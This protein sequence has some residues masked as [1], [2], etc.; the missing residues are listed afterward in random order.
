MPLTRARKALS[1]RKSQS[2]ME[3]LMTYGWAILIIAV[4]LGVLFQLGIFSGSSLTP[5]AQPGSCEVIRTAAATSLE[6]LC[7]GQLP[8][9]VASFNG[10]AAGFRGP[11][12]TLDTITS[13]YTMCAWT[14]ISSYI[15]SSYYPIL[16]SVQWANTGLS[17]DIQSPNF[18]VNAWLDGGGGDS[19]SAASYGAWHFLCGVYSAGSTTRALYI[20][21]KSAGT[22]TNGA[23][24]SATGVVQIGDN[25]NTCC[26][27]TVVPHSR[28]QM[29]SFTM[30]PFLQAR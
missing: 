3:Y 10:I 19:S 17:S 22:V 7:Q 1:R 29:P 6:G 24:L 23:A 20:D 8:Q 25:G 2:A 9:Y 11:S 18:F 12:M 13:G 16:L 30:R 28:K 14:D 26:S 21:G 5:R 15:A 4:V 27:L